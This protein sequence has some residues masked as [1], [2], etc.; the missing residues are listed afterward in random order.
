MAVKESQV[1]LL[2]S[3]SEASIQSTN[4]E[5]VHAMAAVLMCVWQRRDQTVRD[6]LV[7]SLNLLEQ[8]VSV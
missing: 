2:P 5:D 8:P 3:K 6:I 7:A 1:L 4:G